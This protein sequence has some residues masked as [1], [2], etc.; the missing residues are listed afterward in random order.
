MMVSIPAMPTPVAITLLTAASSNDITGPLPGGSRPAF[1]YL[2]LAALR[3]WGDDNQDGVVTAEEAV[4]FAAGVMLD[5]GRPERPALQGESVP[6]AKSGG[7]PMPAYR[8][9]LGR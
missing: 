1:S 5:A 6:L 9:W 4:S 3:G 2:V 7:E 8:D